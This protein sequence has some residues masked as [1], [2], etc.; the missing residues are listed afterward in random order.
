LFPLSAGFWWFFEYL[1]RFVQNWYYVGIDTFGPAEYVLYATLPFSTV[2]PAVLGTKEWLETFPRLNTALRNFR[3]IR[4]THSRA[5]SLVVLVTAGAGLV[6]LGIWPNYLYPLLWL[7][8]LLIMLSIQS[9]YGEQT[10]LSGIR[11]GDWREVW[12]SALAGLICGVFWE[13]WNDRSLAHWE[14][15][16]PYV[17]RFLVFQMPL[18]GYAG[19]LPFG[20]ECVVIADLFLG[21]VGRGTG[22]FSQ[23]LKK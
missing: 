22:Y 15:A 8:P 18:L 5:L 4:I 3:S 12:L 14:Y 20:L 16:V 7:A 9:L 23:P 11:R 1:N 13:L 6:G 2:L 17:H 10:L 21:R 19:Y